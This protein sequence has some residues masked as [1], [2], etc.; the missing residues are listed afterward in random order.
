MLTNVETPQDDGLLLS[1]DQYLQIG[2]DL[3]D[4]QRL[5]ELVAQ[6]LDV[7]QCL[8][9]FVAEVSITYMDSVYSDA[10]IS[11]AST[12]PSGEKHQLALSRSS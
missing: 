9:L 6:A 12:L 8:M 11:W 10:V 5:N 4:L 7:E 3:R 1:S 2:C